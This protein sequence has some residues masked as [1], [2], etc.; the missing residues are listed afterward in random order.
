MTYDNLGTERDV[1]KFPMKLWFLKGNYCLYATLLV[2][3]LILLLCEN[4]CQAMILAARVF[5]AA[6]GR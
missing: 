5:T 6:G 3:L 2:S 1:E 4:I